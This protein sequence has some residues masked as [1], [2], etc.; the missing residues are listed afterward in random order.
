MTGAKS[1]NQQGYIL[2]SVMLIMSLM[3][4]ALSAELP[5]ITQRIKRE[6]EEELVHRGRE[7]A[8][9]VKRFYHKN[10][11]YPVS[12]DQLENTNNLRYLRRRY[13][14][15]MTESG[16]F[17][18]VHL[19]EAQINVPTT[20]A[21]INTGQPNGSNNNTNNTNTQGSGS[22]GTGSTTGT[23]GFNSGSSGFGSSGLSSGGLGSSGSNS[24][25]LSSGGLSSGGLGSGGVGSTGGL[26]SGSQPTLG[27]ATGATTTPGGTQPTTGQMGSLTTQ[28]IGNSSGLQGAGPIIGV[29]STSKKNSIKEFNNANEYDQW[30]FVYDP[31]GEQAGSGG[32]II[33]SPIGTGAPT[34]GIPQP[35][36]TNSPQ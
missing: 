15:P 8:I 31:R 9:A 27:G 36:R 3:L 28:N 6:K 33:A 23:S 12:I 30:M 24:G 17:K 32:V 26:G 18:L 25:G 11:T 1:K 22:S 35:V 2:L 29:A 16:E 5:R 19:G 20:A 21:G 4:I 14:D 7:Y 34:S 10:G 13:K